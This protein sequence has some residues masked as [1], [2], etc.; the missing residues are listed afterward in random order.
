MTEPVQKL[1]VEI[2]NKIFERK[3]ELDLLDWKNAHRGSFSEVRN[4]LG[5]F[6]CGYDHYKC[7]WGGQEEMSPHLLQ[8][9]LSSHIEGLYFVVVGFENGQR[10][11][12][13]RPLKLKILGVEVRRQNS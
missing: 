5:R 10:V 13:I 9:A 7:V 2:V 3:Y 6:W 12:Q 11:F 8:F 1:P 4:E